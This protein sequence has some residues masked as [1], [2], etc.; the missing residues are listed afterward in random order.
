MQILPVLLQLLSPEQVYVLQS[1]Q[2]FRNLLESKTPILEDHLQS[3]I[4]KLLN[5]S[6]NSKYMDIRIVALQC[7]YNCCDYSLIKLLPFKKQV[8][9][10]QV[11]YY[12]TTFVTTIIF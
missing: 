1:L 6:Q 12:F 3:F 5:L 4:P 8:I 10:N 9:N 2:T 11:T 7:L